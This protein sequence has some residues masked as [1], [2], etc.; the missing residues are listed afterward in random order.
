[1]S[2]IY[3]WKNFIKKENTDNHITTTEEI[4]TNIVTEPIEEKVDDNKKVEEESGKQEQKL[5][6][7]ETP[8]KE[9]NKT[10]Q[11]PKQEETK[12]VVKETP[13]EEPTTKKTNPWDELGISEY[14]YYNK[15]IWSW[16]RV[17]YSIKVYG[18]EDKTH[19]ACIDDGNKLENIISFSCTPLNNYAGEYIG[20]MLKIKK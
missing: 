12:P 5:V 8:K 16:A 2:S 14:D 4:K 20:D 3:L 10:T 18:T 19:Q 6:K 7:P 17:D 1:M 15:P 11:T 13:K 9:N